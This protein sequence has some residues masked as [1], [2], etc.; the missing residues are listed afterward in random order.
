MCNL[1]TLPFSHSG[2]VTDRWFEREIRAA[3]PV[4]MRTLRRSHYEEATSQDAVSDAARKAW[5]GRGKWD[6]R[7]EFAT[8]FTAIAINSAK[9]I[10]RSNSRRPMTVSLTDLAERGDASQDPHEASSVAMFSGRV[11]K[12]V[13]D[14][15]ACMRETLLLLAEDLTGQEIAQALGIGHGTVRSRLHRA[16]KLLRAR[17]GAV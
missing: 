4:A 10:A 3:M 2:P 14:L 15:P 13:A 1:C 17:L 12:A 5:Q 16:R 6:G 9:D 8:W 7:S 11:E